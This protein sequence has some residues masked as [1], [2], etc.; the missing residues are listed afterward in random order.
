MSLVASDRVSMDLLQARLTAYEYIGYEGKCML[1][2]NVLSPEECAQWIS[3]SEAVGYEPA[4]I[5]SNGKQVLMP[6]VRQGDR[7]MIDGDTAKLEVL[8]SRLPLTELGTINPRLRFLRYNP[9]DYFMPHHDMRYKRSEWTLH[10]Y[11]NEAFKGGETTFIE[12]AWKVAYTPEA[13]SVILFHQS[14]LHEGNIVVEGRKY[15]VRTEMI[16]S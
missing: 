10:I 1:F 14:L 3:D 5:T 7:C 12:D 9:G 15:S 11:L 8:M 13:G 2:K 6:S 16:T 4:L